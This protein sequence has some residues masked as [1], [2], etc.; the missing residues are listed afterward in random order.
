[1]KY[2]V[3]T[4]SEKG[5]T[6]D[7]DRVTVMKEYAV[8][9][10]LKSVRRFLGLTGYYRRL[11][12]DYSGIASP[13]TNLLREKTTR[14]MW[15]DCALEAFEKFKK[16]MCEAPVVANPDFDTHFLI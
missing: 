10:T 16:T 14:L 12:K 8:P 9:T 15:T 7:S 6:A 4:I 3:Y 13:L 1:M 11:I 2:L 5:I